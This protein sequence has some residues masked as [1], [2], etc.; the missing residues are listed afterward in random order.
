[1]A[2]SLFQV[3]G[4]V[5]TS[6]G[7]LLAAWFII[8]HG[9]RNILWFALLAVLSLLILS[10]VARWY[11]NHLETNRAA[12]PTQLSS[13]ISSHKLKT[14]MAILVALMFSKFVYMSSMHSF[15]S[16][17]LIDKFGL[18]AAQAQSRLFILLAA[19]ASL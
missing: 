14:T 4:N 10:F 17:F 2:Q 11:G 19:V 3:G 15:Y 13:P 18:S 12:T 16:F 6:F 8:P 7:P 9:Q 1:M 5:G